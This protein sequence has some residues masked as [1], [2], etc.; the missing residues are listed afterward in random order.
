MRTAINQG[1]SKAH[2]KYIMKLDAHCMI[3]EGMDTK[4]IREHKSKWIQIP[5]RKRLNAHQWEISEKE[6]P[7]INYMALDRNYMGFKDNFKNRDEKLKEKLIDETEVF[8]GSCYFMEREYFKKLGLLD[9]IN[10]DGS[11][12]EAAEIA[13]K[14]KEDGGKIIRNKKTWYA[15]ARLSRHYVSSKDK[16]RKSI[17]LLYA[18]NSLLH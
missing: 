3:D 5:T 2:G 14:V 17:K 4:L 10:F 18:G 9:D 12:H 13:Y 6:K 1:V 11:G 8:Q 15:H 7:D 16:S